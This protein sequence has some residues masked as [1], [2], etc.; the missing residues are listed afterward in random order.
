MFIVESGLK[1]VS[2]FMPQGYNIKTW[3]LDDVLTIIQ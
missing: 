3:D 1:F 2:N